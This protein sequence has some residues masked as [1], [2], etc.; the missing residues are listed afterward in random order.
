[1]I[2]T[3][4]YTFIDSTDKFKIKYAININ[5]TV[6]PSDTSLRGAATIAT[7]VS[8]YLAKWPT[9]QCELKVMISKI[10]YD[11]RLTRLDT[12]EEEISLAFKGDVNE[13]WK[14]LCTFTDD[15]DAKFNTSGGFEQWVQKALKKAATT[16]EQLTIPTRNDQSSSTKFK[17]DRQEI[18]EENVG[19]A[20][21][22]GTGVVSMDPIIEES[23]RH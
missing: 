11:M 12:G 3:V 22:E 9:G 13:D 8:G 23:R 19:K 4:D 5:D 1:M 20:I 7:D 10:P 16:L 17:I 21:I 14:S 15:P 2:I 18:N 6:K